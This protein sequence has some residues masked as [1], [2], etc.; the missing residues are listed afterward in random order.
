MADPPGLSLTPPAAGYDFFFLDKLIAIN[1][2]RPPLTE[3]DIPV[4]AKEATG[5]APITNPNDAGRTR[6]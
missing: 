2:N 5:L 6:R 3:S 4:I 1:S